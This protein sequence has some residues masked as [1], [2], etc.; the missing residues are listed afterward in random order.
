MLGPELVLPDRLVKY[1]LGTGVSNSLW[2]MRE[3]MC[4][5]RRDLVKA[6]RQARRDLEKA[7]MAES[8]LSKWRSLLDAGEARAESELMLFEGKTFA[9]RRGGYRRMGPA[10]PLSIWQ[11]FK[12]AY[13]LPRPVGDCLL[14]AYA[15]VR[16]AMR[17]AKGALGR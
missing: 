7:R 1:R 2:R 13:L 10:R 12:I 3:P 17:R 5:S 14:F 4:R 6:Y 11:F 8:E 15:V 16:Y 9:E